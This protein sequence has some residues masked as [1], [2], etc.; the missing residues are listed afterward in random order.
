MQAKVIV[1][2]YINRA[3]A[4]DK[5]KAAVDKARKT[6]EKLSALESLQKEN[7]L[8]DA[9]DLVL[10]LYNELFDFEDILEAL[11]IK[12]ICESAQ[13]KLKDCAPALAKVHKLR[14]DHVGYI[15][16]DYS[17]NRIHLTTKKSFEEILVLFENNLDELKTV[18]DEAIL[19]L[20][21]SFGDSSL[22]LKENL[23]SKTY[24]VPPVEEGNEL[25]FLTERFTQ[26]TAANQHKFDFTPLQY[27]AHLGCVSAVEVFCD[28]LAKVEPKTPRLT[29]EYG[30]LA[31]S[32]SAKC[33]DRVIPI[34]VKYFPSEITNLLI[35]AMQSD[36]Y[37]SVKTILNSAMN[38][39][40]LNVPDLLSKMLST[41]H[42]C[43][44]AGKMLALASVVSKDADLVKNRET[45]TDQ[46]TQI[47]EYGDGHDGLNILMIIELLKWSARS[48]KLA[49]INNT[50]Q[51][52]L[53]LFCQK[54]HDLPVVIETFSKLT[55]RQPNLADMEDNLGN[56]PLHYAIQS[57]MTKSVGALLMSTTNINKQN[58]E[59]KTALHLAAEIGNPDIINILYFK[60]ADPFV[61]DKEGKTPFDIIKE[62]KVAFTKNNYDEKDRIKA[63]LDL[64]KTNNGNDDK[65]KAK[66]F[67][68]ALKEAL[69]EYNKL[70]SDE[71]AQHEKTKVGELT[72]KINLLKKSIRQV[73]SQQQNDALKLADLVGLSNLQTNKLEV[74]NHLDKKLTA[75]ENS[76]KLLTNYTR[77]FDEKENVPPAPAIRRQ[78]KYTVFKGG[79]PKGTANVEALV[80]SLEDNF[81]IPEEQI[82]T[83]GTSAG[84]IIGLLWALKNTGKQLKGKLFNLEFMSFLDDVDRNHT[85]NVMK[86]GDSIKALLNGTASFYSKLSTLSSLPA[87]F[88]ELSKH[89]SGL[90]KGEVY[91][92]WI[93]DQILEKVRGTEVLERINVEL[94]QEQKKEYDALDTEIKKQEYIL[95]KKVALITFQ[96]FKDFPNL[97]LE[98]K[99]FGT[100]IA[101]QRGEEYSVEKTPN[102]TILS[103]MRI[104][105]SLPIVFQPAY[106]EERRFVREENG[107]RFYQSVRVDDNPRIDGGLFDNYPASAFDVD[108]KTGVELYNPHTL[109]FCLVP[110]HQ[111]QEFAC[112]GPT[113]HAAVDDKSFLDY[114][115]KMIL[116]VMWGQ[117]DYYHGRGLDHER[118]VYVSTLDVGTLDFNISDRKKEDLCDSGGAVG[119]LD[120]QGAHG[121]TLEPTSL[122]VRTRKRLVKNGLFKEFTHH[123]HV[124]SRFEPGH[125]VSPV[126]ILKLYAKADEK[127]L[128]TLSK[129]VNP[130]TRDA[131]GITALH[132]ARALGFKD[133]YDRL[134]RYQANENAESKNGVI[135]SRTTWDDIKQFVN[136]KSQ[137]QVSIKLPGYL[138]DGSGKPKYLEK[139]FVN[140]KKSKLRHEVHEKERELGDLE[141]RR[142]EE[143]KSLLAEKASELRNLREQKERELGDL[144]RRRQEENERLLANQ[145]TELEQLIAQNQ[146]ALRELTDREQQARSNLER[147]KNAE[148]EQKNR[149]LAELKERLERE[150]NAEIEQKNREL[151]ELRERLEREKN[152]VIEQ[153]NQELTAVREELAGAVHER[154]TNHAQLDPK[155]M[156]V[157]LFRRYIEAKVT[158]KL[159]AVADD[160][161]DQAIKTSLNQLTGEVSAALN[162]HADLDG[163]ARI[164][165]LKEDLV[166]LLN[167]IIDGEDERFTPL[168]EQVWYMSLLK[169]LAGIIA[170]FVGFTV[171]FFFEGYRNTFFN[172]GYA[173]QLSYI[174]QDVDYFEQQVV[175][176]VAA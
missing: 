86:N 118:T 14:T 176:V 26:K 127:D 93:I 122:S 98:F 70:I 7:K 34:L 101:T 59:G 40:E 31:L 108:P 89:R 47:R 170:G 79:G 81:V 28:R 87:L 162:G 18:Q 35:D 107:K 57:N 32:R 52:L 41:S 136:T 173:N 44:D 80:K 130:N 75:L 24:M 15:S 150:K 46:I 36:D 158:A 151:A 33:E 90:F 134:V 141:K 123:Q 45:I 165:A 161:Q 113:Q 99:C 42:G 37:V 4:H 114:L 92:D 61:K 97:F 1:Q 137:D 8:S 160:E 117:Q 128:P 88:N 50:Q 132:L 104:T 120:Y 56:L 121:H 153:K 72:A 77:S 110:P 171:P 174:R 60:G 111:F 156:I 144:E 126:E 139:D 152:T 112:D 2:D 64:M 145:A 69:L 30:V 65:D 67:L 143:N 147:D 164:D 138:F 149:E 169:G 54:G 119:I 39:A 62:K 71:R 12:G 135:A 82:G 25:K 157:S 95:R 146:N 142:R 166:E 55:L 85:E 159:R 78:I 9:N 96:D 125:L 21:S 109:G 16:K 83:A 6:L 106:L 27:A 22:L 58:K 163:K 3:V 133:T 19:A 167:N 116:A 154:D 105:M 17:S 115:F 20:N 68:N 10:R 13:S 23:L 103:A 148:I 11:G 168:T 5:L 66:G 100:N 49:H 172:G 73:L 29:G 53:H 63:D 91:K 175:P 76:A 51:N 38:D 155:K 131:N 129:L 140:S 94:T 48:G 74:Q 84:A 124:H 43:F 102:A